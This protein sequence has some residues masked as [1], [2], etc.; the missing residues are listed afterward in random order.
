MRCVIKSKF[1]PSDW[2]PVE[3]VERSNKEEPPVL[4]PPG[5]DVLPDADPFPLF[6]A[7]DKL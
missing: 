4:A 2:F 5:V 6:K 7:D 1:P 3:R